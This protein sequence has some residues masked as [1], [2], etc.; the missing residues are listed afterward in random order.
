MGSASASSVSALSP[1]GLRCRHRPARSLIHSFIAMSESRSSHNQT[2]AEHADASGATTAAATGAVASIPAWLGPRPLSWVSAA[3]RSADAVAFD[4]DSTVSADEGVDVLAEYLHMGPQIKAL[5]DR[6]MNGTVPFEV[7]LRDRLELLRPSAAAV[8]ACVA[9]RPPVFSPG[10]EAF[11]AFWRAHHAARNGGAALPVFLVSGGFRPLIEPL[12][13]QLCIDEQSVFANTLQFDADGSYSSF[14]EHEPTSRSG[15]K[16][17]ALATLSARHGFN[18]MVMVGDGATD[19]EA[20]PPA[21]VM[22]GYGGVVARETVKQ[23]A[24]VFVNN[25]DELRAIIEQNE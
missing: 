23:K 19:L 22:V 15:G 17:C 3:L 8:A 2:A 4:V 5:T 7:A 20:C 13:L 25:W 1:F 10:F 21:H 12:R 6:A 9:E 11:I 14:D 24:H 16:A 18:R